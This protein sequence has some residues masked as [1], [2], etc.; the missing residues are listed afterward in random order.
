M[1]VPSVVPTDSI[2][3]SGNT[4]SWAEPDSPGGV[5]LSYDILFRESVNTRAT[6]G[7]ELQIVTVNANVTEYDVSRSGLPDGEYFVQVKE[8][9]IH[10]SFCI[11]Q[12]VHT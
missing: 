2:R 10:S 5:I 8:I 12:Y 11:L 6:P 1:P 3:S 4:L 7:E 9:I